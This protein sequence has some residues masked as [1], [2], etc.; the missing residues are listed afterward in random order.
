MA[1][2]SV[3]AQGHLYLFYLYIKKSNRKEYHVLTEQNPSKATGD[4]VNIVR[5]ETDKIQGQ[6]E[7]TFER[8]VNDLETYN[9]SRKYQTYIEA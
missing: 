9:K 6:K 4:N 5:R 7:G 2:C 1:W 8:K 3:Q